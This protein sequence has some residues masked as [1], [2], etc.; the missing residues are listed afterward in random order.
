MILD[1][2]STKPSQLSFIIIIIPS[3]TSTL[4]YNVLNCAYDFYRNII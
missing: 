4:F 1:D 3:F 2:S